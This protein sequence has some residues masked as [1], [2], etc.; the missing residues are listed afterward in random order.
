MPCQRRG[1]LYHVMGFIEQQ[2]RLRVFG[3]RAVYLRAALAVTG[4]HIQGKPR[5]QGGF[6][7]FTP[8]KEKAF[9]VLSASCVT[10]YKTVQSLNKRLLKQLKGNALS[11]PL[12]FRMLA[13]TFSKGYGT[14]CPLFVKDILPGRVGG[15]RRKAGVD[16]FHPP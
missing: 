9:S 15:R 4:Q 8:H 11:C 1:L 12:A 3:C 16:L 6:T 13:E 7:V 5:K 10:V 14:A 2:T